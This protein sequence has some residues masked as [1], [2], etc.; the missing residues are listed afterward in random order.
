[1]ARRAPHSAQNR[2]PGRLVCR[3]D[4]QGVFGWVSTTPWRRVAAEASPGVGRPVNG[5]RCPVG[6]GRESRRDPPTPGLMATSAVRPSSCASEPSDLPTQRPVGLVAAECPRPDRVLEMSRERRVLRADPLDALADPAGD[7]LARPIRDVAG[8][9]RPPASCARPGDTEGTA[10]R[11]DGSP[12]TPRTPVLGDGALPGHFVRCPGSGAAHLVSRS[13]R[14]PRAS[15]SGW[16]SAGRT[17]TRGSRPTLTSSAALIW[18]SLWW[19]RLLIELEVEPRAS[20][21]TAGAGLR[22]SLG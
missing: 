1:M 4:G 9:A 5:A 21:D 19:R 2:L 11:P 6:A 15:C 20:R 16:A 3:Q 10:M 18:R 13:S 7:G 8:L 17:T 12:P 14:P 22:S